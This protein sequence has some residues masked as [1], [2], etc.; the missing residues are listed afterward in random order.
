MSVNK[1]YKRLNCLILIFLLCLIGYNYPIS[2]LAISPSMAQEIKSTTNVDIY[3]PNNTNTSNTNSNQ[4]IDPKIQELIDEFGKNR[5]SNTDLIYAAAIADGCSPAA[6]A[7]LAGNAYG[8]GAG[9]EGTPVLEEYLKDENGHPLG[10]GIFGFSVGNRD[11]LQEF[12]S[13]PSHANHPKIDITCYKSSND[14]TAVT[15]TVCNN[16]E[17][18]MEFTLTDDEYGLAQLS[19]YTNSDVYND[20]IKNDDEWPYLQENAEVGNIPAEIHIVGHSPEEFKRTND[21][22]T[23]VVQWFMDYEMSGGALCIKDGGK[24][25]SKFR[26]KEYMEDGVNSLHSRYGMA[27]S[28]CHDGA[29]T[30]NIN[31]NVDKESA[32]NLAL[33]MQEGGVWSE[34][35]MNKF[36]GLCR[37][38]ENDWNNVLDS[39]HFKDISTRGR[40]SI[41]NWKTNKEMYEENTSLRAIMRGI[42]TFIGIIML[43]YAILLYLTYWFDR[44]NTLL[45]WSLFTILTFGKLQI[46]YDE[47]CANYR[48]TNVKKG[49]AKTVAHRD[50]LFICLII[51]GFSVLILTGGM[52]KL[53]LW[54]VDMISHILS[55]F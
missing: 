18:Q 25:K 23:A 27:L 6:A 30:A 10:F 13:G 17:C 36:S 53:L 26:T 39:Q 31:L 7:A 34:T 29:N 15:Y 1:Y 32:V 24:H 42:L 47:D 48:Q 14:H 44:S 28:Y 4:P 3:N 11:K 8:E 38:T 51:I 5:N 55:Y 21:V 52:F 37:L 54:I 33:A 22:G 19:T 49:E 43:V 45:P 50:V 16:I 35:E 9:E 2:V 12:C 40:E 41:A 20:R 46:A